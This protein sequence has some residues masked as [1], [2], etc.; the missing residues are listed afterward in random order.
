MVLKWFLLTNSH[1]IFKNQTEN[2]ET[3]F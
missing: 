3:N 1:L 2:D